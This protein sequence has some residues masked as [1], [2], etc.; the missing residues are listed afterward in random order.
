MKFVEIKFIERLYVAF[1]NFVSYRFFAVRRHDGTK[2]VNGQLH[3]PAALLQWN[4]HPLHPLHTTLSC[5]RNRLD[6]VTNTEVTSL[7]RVRTLVTQ[8]D[9]SYS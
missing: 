2:L 5:P 1:K 9:A 4:S 6:A 8:T 7:A 3:A